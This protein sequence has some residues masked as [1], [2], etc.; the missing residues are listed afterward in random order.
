MF[1]KNGYLVVSLLKSISKNKAMDRKGNPGTLYRTKAPKI[2]IIKPIMVKR[3]NTN[4]K[5]KMT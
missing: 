2:G 3:I 4:D 1:F 5:Q